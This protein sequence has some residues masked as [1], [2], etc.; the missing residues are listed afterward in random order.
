[1]AILLLHLNGDGNG[2]KFLDQ[3]DNMTAIAWMIRSS[4][5]N[6]VDKADSRIRE[7]ISRKL[8]DLMGSAD[9]G[10]YLQHVPGI[11]N[12]IADILSRHR[13]D[14]NSQIHSLLLQEAKDILENTGLELKIVDVPEVI[15]CWI[16]SIVEELMRIKALPRRQKRRI[17][18]ILENG[19]VS[20]PVPDL[21][22][23]SLTRDQKEEF[24][25]SV[26]SR[27]RSDIIDLAKKHSIDFEEIR[28]RFPSTMFARPSSRMDFH[29]LN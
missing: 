18:N 10:I 6:T 15:I 4:Y 24:K 1:M 8:A 19:G 26:R 7:V 23:S 20:Q 16:K 13:N 14:S 25:S 17:L 27:S 29:P 12:I 2:M 28:L 5:F 11:E 22:F 3:S 9:I 21:T